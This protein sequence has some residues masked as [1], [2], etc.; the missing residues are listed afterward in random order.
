MIF[1]FHDFNEFADISQHL[2]LVVQSSHLLFLSVLPVVVARARHAYS[3]QHGVANSWELFA[4]QRTCQIYFCSGNFSR[5]I[6]L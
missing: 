6:I 4:C 1:N 5:I 3:E 2:C